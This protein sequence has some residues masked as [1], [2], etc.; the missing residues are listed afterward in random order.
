MVYEVRNDWM[1]FAALADATPRP[2]IYG[3]LFSRTKHGARQSGPQTGRTRDSL[4]GTLTRSLTGTALRPEGFQERLDRVLVAEDIAA[5]GIDVDGISHVVITIHETIS[6]IVHRIG[7]TGTRTL[8]WGRPGAS[9]RPKIPLS[10]RWNGLL[11][12]AMP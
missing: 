7:R 8:G 1:M 2:S 9:R 3:V 4:H 11:A 10:A 5:R 12:A 6:R